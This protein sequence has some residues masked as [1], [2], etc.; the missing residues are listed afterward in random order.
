LTNT[1]R[2]SKGLSTLAVSGEVVSV[3]RRWA[4]HMAA[5]GAISHNQNL[6]NEVPLAWTKLGENVGVGGTVDAIQNAFINSPT[7][8]KNLVDPAWNYVGIGVVDSGGR[9]W[10]TV[11]FMQYGA[12]AATAAPAPAAAPRA[13][14]RAQTAPRPAPAPAP[15]P[16]PVTAPPPPAPAPAPAPVAA[17]EPPVP[18]PALT[19]ALDQLRAVDEEF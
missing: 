16:T 8:Y 15:R 17:P 11:N 2:A 1:L 14:P 19:L 10:V 6:P 5:A 9:I 18:S 3:A 13:V 12:S 4:A 7:H